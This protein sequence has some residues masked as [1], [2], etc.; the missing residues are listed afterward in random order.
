MSQTSFGA[1]GEL[2]V[3]IRVDTSFATANLT[4][5]I[6]TYEVLERTLIRTLNTSARLTGDENLQRGTRV[7]TLATSAIQQY[8][9][10]TNLL[11]MTNPLFWPLGV[12]GLIGATMTVTDIAG[13]F[14]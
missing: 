11:M 13:S 2:V 10:A 12:L 9:L 14:A 4:K 8:I 3:G 1:E 6:T 7:V 5:L